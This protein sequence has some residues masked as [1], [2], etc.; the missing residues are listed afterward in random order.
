MTETRKRLSFWLCSV[1]VL[2]LSGCA[3]G[4]NSQHFTVSLMPPAPRQV[5]ASA[6]VDA[7]EVTAPTKISETPI[8]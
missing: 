5:V 8:F 3:T 6:V 2:V 4:S 1:S 7:P